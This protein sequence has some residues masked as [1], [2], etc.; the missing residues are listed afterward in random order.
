MLF[1]WVVGVIAGIVIGLAVHFAVGGR[2]SAAL[3]ALAGLLGAAVGRTIL[4]HA[5]RWHPHFLGSLIGGIVLALIWVF[6]TRGG[7]PGQSAAA[8]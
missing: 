8:E 2:K 4:G 1:S 5:F 7:S 6:A 3:T